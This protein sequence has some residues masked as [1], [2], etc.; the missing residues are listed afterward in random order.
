MSKVDRSCVGCGS[1][2]TRKDRHR[3]IY[4]CTSCQETDKF[5]LIY[6]SYVKEKYFIEVS[7][8]EAHGCE[9]FLVEQSRWPTKTLYKVSDVLD[10]FCVKYNIE[11]T[12]SEAIQEKLEE[13]KER[14][15]SIKAERA[16]KRAA[17][18]QTASEQRRSNLVTA[19]TAVGLELRQ[20]SK[21][22][23]GYIDGTIKDWDLPSIVR[24]MC[25]MKYLYDYCHMDE[26]YDEA[27]TEQDEE[28][29]AGYFPD[30]STFDL[31][32]MIALR[33]YGRNG[34]YPTSWPWLSD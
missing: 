18:K 20:D 25:Q 9:F 28:Y 2:S 32:E 19:L 12:N 5:K 1:S 15:S 3:H 26:C 33:K 11:R 23:Q 8:L 4:L 30:Q 24:R 7:D 22:C 10:L 31:A 13:L 17:K 27:E 29:R 6:K 16:Q 34:Q 21:L 14:Q